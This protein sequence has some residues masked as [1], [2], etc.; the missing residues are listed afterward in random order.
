MGVSVL[1]TETS[2]AMGFAFDSKLANNLTYFKN[3]VMNQ[4]WDCA[5]FIDGTEGGGKSVLA[6]Q[7]ATFLDVDNELSLD[8]IIFDISEWEKAVLKTPKFKA[9]VFDEAGRGFDRRS[10]GTAVNK[11]LRRLLW[12]CRKRNLFLIFVMPSYYDADMAIAVWRTRALIHVWYD[13]EQIA[14]DGSV[15]SKPLVRGLARLYN[16]QAKNEM[17]TNEKLRKRYSYPRIPNGCLDFRFPQHYCVN[18]EEYLA[19]KDQSEAKKEGAQKQS[20]DRCPT[21]GVG[22]R[23]SKHGIRC[24]NGHK[25]PIDST[26]TIKKAVVSEA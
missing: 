1:R 22:V 11:N 9:V 12:E 24:F 16:E 7:I 17:W 13:W 4:D 25:F 21:C 20:G 3:A 2:K 10:S 26:H 14:A 23:H 15:P 5:M 6:Q 8:R 18:K 19:K